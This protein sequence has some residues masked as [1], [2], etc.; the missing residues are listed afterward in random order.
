MDFIVPLLEDLGMAFVEIGA[1]F[2]DHLDQFDEME[3]E[4]KALTDRA[5]AQFME[6]MLNYVDELLCQSSKRKG[7]YDIQRHRQRTLVTT[8]GDITF[9]HTLFKSRD[10][11]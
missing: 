3:S 5:A 10:D 11:G 6:G 8:A 9:T 4:A 7:A 2:I 1:D